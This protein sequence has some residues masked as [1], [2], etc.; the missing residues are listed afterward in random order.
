MRY[1]DLMAMNLS[2]F[3][4]LFKN[5]CNRHILISPIFDCNPIYPASIRIPYLVIYF[6]LILLFTSLVYLFNESLI[7]PDIIYSPFVFIIYSVVVAIGANLFLYLLSSVFYVNRG[8]LR[9]I[10]ND[11]KNDDETFQKEW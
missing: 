6:T 5:L 4:F 3:G 7:Y 9:M 2:F 1:R 8:R 11:V 10:I